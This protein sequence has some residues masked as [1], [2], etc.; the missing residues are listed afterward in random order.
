[1]H[2][3]KQLADLK[4]RKDPIGKGEELIKAAFSLYLWTIKLPN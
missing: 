1:M 4:A 2:P 3:G